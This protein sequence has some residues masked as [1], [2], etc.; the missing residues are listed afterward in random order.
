MVC[1]VNVTHA[2]IEDGKKDK[3]DGKILYTDIIGAWRINVINMVKASRDGKEFLNKAGFTNYDITM[4]KL[5]DCKCKIKVTVI[6]NVSTTSETHWYIGDTLLG[7]ITGCTCVS[8]S[9]ATIK[10]D[11]CANEGT[12]I[13]ASGDVEEVPVKIKGVEM[14]AKLAD[15]PESDTDQLLCSKTFDSCS[16]SVTVSGSAFVQ[17]HMSGCGIGFASGEAKVN[18]EVIVKCW[19]DCDGEIKD[20]ST[21]RSDEQLKSSSTGRKSSANQKEIEKIKK[22]SEK[23]SVDE[24]KKGKTSNETRELNKIFNKLKIDLKKQL[25]EK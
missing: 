17:S 11:I 2:P 8:T 3:S 6:G 18:H 21:W 5:P 24:K 14:P 7:W 16:A 9:K 12:A 15:A 23:S 10:A 19:Y 20:K 4:P 1:T 13:S 25:T 22:V